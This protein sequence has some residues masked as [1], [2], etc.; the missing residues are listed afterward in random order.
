MP[1][2]WKIHPIYKSAFGFLDGDV[3]RKRANGHWHT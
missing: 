2:L 3:F 1:Q